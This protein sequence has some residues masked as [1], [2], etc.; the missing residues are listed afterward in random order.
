MFKKLVIITAL[1]GIISSLFI[2]SIVY[3]ADPTVDTKEVVGSSFT[4]KDAEASIRAR[5]AHER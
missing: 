1:I 3:A 4:K 5:F 2:P